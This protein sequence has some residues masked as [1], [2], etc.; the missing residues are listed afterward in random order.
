MESVDS[1]ASH[2]GMRNKQIGMMIMN[3]LLDIAKNNDCYKSSL[4][5]NYHNL[6]FYENCGYKD[7][8]IAMYLLTGG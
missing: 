1:I 8:G 2:P 4:N 6:R 3:A 5:C 7:N